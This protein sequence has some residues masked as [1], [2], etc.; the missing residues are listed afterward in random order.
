MIGMLDP[1]SRITGRGQRRLRS[2]NIITE[3]FPHDL[4]S[5][6]EEL[7]REFSRQFENASRIE[8]PATQVQQPDIVDKWVNLG[9]EHKSGVAKTLQDQGYDLGWVKADKEAE[10]VEFEGWE[11]VL[12]DQPSVKIACLTIHD[13][14]AVGGHLVLLKRPNPSKGPS[15]PASRTGLTPY[16]SSDRALL[17]INLRPIPSASLTTSSI[18]ARPWEERPD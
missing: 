11:Y 16:F 1:D 4:L 10:K 12:I 7:N 8:T 2:A 14:P 18:C 3:F 15:P 5:E 17:P 6:V 13:H 9:Y